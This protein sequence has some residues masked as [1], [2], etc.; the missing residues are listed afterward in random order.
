[1]K[2]DGTV[3][4]LVH[5]H[6]RQLAQAMTAL[7]GAIAGLVLLG[8]QYDA[9][10]LKSGVPGLVAMNPLTA[11]CFLLSA[12][13]LTL[14]HRHLPASL[15]LL[16]S[17]CA[18]VVTACG[19]VCLAGYLRGRPAGV[20]QVF[21][22]AKLHIEGAMPNRMAPNTAFDFVALGVALVLNPVQRKGDRR[23]SQALVLLVAL[24]AFVA[25]LGYAYSVTS[26]IR[27]AAFIPM[28][29]PTA[30]CFVLLAAAALL[31]APNGGFME[32][33]TSA[34]PGGRLVR[35]LVPAFVVGPAVLG[36][37]RLQGELVGLYNSAFGTAMMIGAL[38]AM[39]VGLTWANAVSLDR[40]D[41]ARRHTEQMTKQLAYYDALTG[42][43]NRD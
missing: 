29:V 28:A 21:F 10:V 1:M 35:R 43:P 9:A 30:V 39:G 31:W 24:T 25:L 14:A 12:L 15:R 7:A 20:D 11:I 2:E 19:L 37:V 4:G 13:A 40:A 8:W 42:L 18:A 32:R 34:T 36:W 23:L 3:E 26:L 38:G 27:Y 33:A 5:R 16:P 22:A 6:Y 17:A 41:E